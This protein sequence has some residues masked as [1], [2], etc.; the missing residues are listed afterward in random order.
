V[1][2][3][4][5][6][7]VATTAVTLSTTVLARSPMSAARCFTVLA[8][9]RA[10][11]GAFFMTFTALRAVCATRPALLAGLFV[12]PARFFAVAAA[13]RRFVVL[14]DAADF[15]A[16]LRAMSA[17]EDADVFFFTE[18]LAL[19]L[20]ALPDGFFAG[21]RFAFAD[22]GPFFD[23]DLPDEPRFAAFLAMRPP[24]GD[25]I[26]TIP[27]IRAK[28][29]ARRA[30]GVPRLAC[31]A[32]TEPGLHRPGYTSTS[33][34]SL[35]RLQVRVRHSLGEKIV[36]LPA[37]GVDH[38]V[39]IGRSASA[40]LQIPSVHIGPNHL[41]L[42]VHDGRW[43]V[44]DGSD[45]T[46][47]TID[48]K[49]L[50]RPKILYGREVLRLGPDG[51]AAALEI[52][53]GGALS[54]GAPVPMDTTAAVAGPSRLD[55]D[56]VDWATEPLPPSYYLPKPRKSSPIVVGIAIV[57]A[58]AIVAGAGVFVFLRKPTPP[59]VVT[60]VVPGEQRAKTGYPRPTTRVI[61]APPPPPPPD[62]TEQLDK[63]PSPVAVVPVSQASS[64]STSPHT[65]QPTSPPLPHSVALNDDAVVP[66]PA[67]ASSTEPAEDAEE[68]RAWKHI[69]TVYY[70]ADPSKPLIAMDTFARDYP[71]SHNAELAQYREDLFDKLW[72]IR[73]DGLCDRRK[74]LTAAMAET[75]QKLKTEQDEAYK[76]T[77][78]QPEL[79]NQK[80][81][82][83]KVNERLATEMN[84]RSPDPPPIGKETEIAKLRALRVAPAYETWKKQVMKSLHDSHGQLP[85][86]NER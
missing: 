9:W 4:K 12:A 19:V 28:V 18:R 17:R 46:G 13:P 16:P 82:L 47:S 69:Q 78:L 58:S 42:F 27:S 30:R 50:L 48:G 71:G 38:P 6:V 26:L 57:T 24:F 22:D 35:M 67:D 65:T 81:K 41:A 2:T 5:P 86:V 52:D 3:A 84:Y 39:I 68:A 76:K 37:R 34:V 74:A 54:A 32:P 72:W 7:A 20:A 49:P 14:A 63:P 23:F 10:F 11:A 40:D 62:L 70:D 60:V 43:I 1:P 36:E 83:A 44:Q 73:I 66:P 31:W 15:D 53:P 25:R 33:E 55:S 56:H 64:N 51:R 61:P 8:T 79:D 29:R 21:F 75:Q 45:S 85:W 80:S 59:N 77:V